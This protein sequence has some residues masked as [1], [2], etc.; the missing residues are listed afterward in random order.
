MRPRTQ[1][2]GGC[3]L[4]GPREWRED[5]NWAHARLTIFFLFLQTFAQTYGEGDTQ[6]QTTPAVTHLT[7]SDRRRA[8]A[9]YDGLK[10]SK[11]A[12]VNDGVGAPVE[13]SWVAGPAAALPG[14]TTS[15]VNTAGG[16]G[17]GGGSGEGD[18]GLDSAMD[19]VGG[20][21]DHHHDHSE[22]NGKDGQRAGEEEDAG[23]GAKGE[24]QGQEKGQQNQQQQTQEPGEAKAEVDYDVAGENEWDE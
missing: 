22:D 3:D 13:V 16:G 17:A 20:D 6:I 18:D 10:T 9:F 19:D 15:S 4:R 7:F 14:S 11:I 12:G 21:D 8:E 24:P 2:L 1:H 23:D 5:R